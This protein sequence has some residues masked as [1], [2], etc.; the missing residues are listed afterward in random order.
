M[1]T[2]TP[3]INSIVADATESR[4]KERGFLPCVTTDMRKSAVVN[5][6]RALRWEKQ[7][8][9]KIVNDIIFQHSVPLVET[10]IDIAI[11]DRNPNAINSLLDRGFGK[12]AQ[13]V[14]IG[15]QVDNPIVFM[16]AQLMT[17]YKIT[18]G[19][20]KPSESTDD[21]KSGDQ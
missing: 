10:L 17:K 5:Y 4:I 14:N 15:G 3:T 21:T 8:T 20:Y 12:A 6:E 7:K 1:L 2:E 19:V 11:T 13:D 16:P 9:Q 18:E